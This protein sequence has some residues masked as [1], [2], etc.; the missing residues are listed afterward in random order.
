MHPWWRCADEFKAWAPRRSA[1]CPKTS[2]RCRWPWRTSPSHSRR[3]LS[4]SLPLTWK[5]TKLGW[6][7]LGQYRETVPFS[8]PE[9]PEPWKQDSQLWKWWKPWRGVC[10]TALSEL[11]YVN[12]AAHQGSRLYR[13]SHQKT[14][15]FERAWWKLSV[16]SLLP[17]HVLSP[18]CCFDMTVRA[19]TINHPAADWLKKR[20]EER[21]DFLLHR[22][23]LM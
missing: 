13:G 14:G 4:P 15:A 22:E 7:S 16:A 6:P 21:G 5:N 11:K 23:L 9:G 3:S 19:E 10:V 17:F 8:N 1:L 20:E 12:R 18:R 2:C